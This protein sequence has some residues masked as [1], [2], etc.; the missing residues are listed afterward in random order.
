[1]RAIVLCAAVLLAGATA[2]SAVPTNTV[3]PRLPLRAT[4][5]A[6]NW[7][8]MYEQVLSVVAM[9]YSQCPIRNLLISQSYHEISLGF[10]D[11]INVGQDENPVGGT[12][13]NWPTIASWASN[14]VGDNIRN[15]TVRFFGLAFFLFVTG[16]GLCR[17]ATVTMPPPRQ[18]MRTK[19][20]PGI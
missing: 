10:K 4:S 20:S 15:L 17:C 11:L 6:M 18:P 7:T 9:P 8:A 2:A 12:Q 14:S 3:I 5:G 13:M 1:M 19:P 16:T